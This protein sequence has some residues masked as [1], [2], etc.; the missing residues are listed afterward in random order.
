[1]EI[2][3]RSEKLIRRAAEHIDATHIGDGYY[4]YYADET[5]SYWVVDEEDLPT[6]CGYLD[7]PDEDIRRDAYSHWCARTTGREMPD[8]WTPGD[9]VET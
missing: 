5:S 7:D 4:A 2:T 3:N 8:G 1:M 9:Y 6:L